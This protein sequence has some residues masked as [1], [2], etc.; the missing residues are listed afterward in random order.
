MKMQ[1]F[2]LLDILKMVL[3]SAMAA[4]AFQ[5]FTFPNSIVSGGVTGIAQIVHLLSSL[6]TGVLNIVLNIPLFVICWRHLGLRVLVGALAV[7]IMVSVFIDLFALTKAAA[8]DDPLL[9]SVYGGVLHGA[10]YGLIYTTGVTGGGIDILAKLLRRKYPHINFGNFILGMNVMVVLT[11]AILFHK[12]ESCMYT[13]IEMFISSKVINLLLYGSNVSTVC[14]IIS[15][16]PAEISDAINREMHRGVTF[17]RGQG[18]WSGHD[19]PVI[20][21]V[22]KRPEIAQMRALVRNVDEKAFFIVTEAKDVFGKN[23]EN[24]RQED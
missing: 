18:G 1:Q 15:S 14:Y 10:G 21:C 19:Q 6:P 13:M 24:I 2:S 23:F 3:G 7:M 17:L 22:I 16:V 4:A 8:T 11:F 5:Y 9:A 12:Y 20:L